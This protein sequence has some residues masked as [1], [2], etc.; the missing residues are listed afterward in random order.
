ML[1]YAI[2]IKLN[3]MLPCDLS[4][5]KFDETPISSIKKIKLSE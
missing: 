4:K 2:N 5:E 1:P 3:E